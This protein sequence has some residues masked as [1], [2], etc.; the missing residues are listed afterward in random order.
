MLREVV[1]KIVKLHIP[2]IAETAG[3]RVL[4]ERSPSWRE[5]TLIKKKKISERPYLLREACLP[6]GTNQ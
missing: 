5:K 2:R 1:S 3:S 6:R 4:L